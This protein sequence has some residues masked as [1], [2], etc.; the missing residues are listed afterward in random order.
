MVAKPGL[1]IYTFAPKDVSGDPESCQQAH[2][3]LKT[4]WRRCDVL[5]IKDSVSGL[6]TPTE[7]PTIFAVHDPVFRILAA[8]ANVEQADTGDYQAFLFEY[9]DVLGF[10]ANLEM[11]C[12]ATDIKKWRVLLDEWT[13][14]TAAEMPSAI[15]GEFYLFTALHEHDISLHDSKGARDYMTTVSNLTKQAS[16]AFSTNGGPPWRATSPYISDEGY[17]IWGGDELNKR[18]TVALLAPRDKEDQLFKWTVWPEPGFLAPFARYLM[19]TAKLHYAQQVFDAEIQGLRKISRELDQALGDIVSVYQ[20]SEDEGMWRQHEITE[21]HKGLVLE[22]RR[23]FDLM[24]G[25]SKLTELSFTT[26]IAARNMQELLPPPHP[27]MKLTDNTFFE[28]DRVRGAWLSEQIQMDLGYLTA[29]RERVS[30]GH[31]IASLLLERETQKTSRRLKNLV[32]IQGTLI[33]S[34]TIGLLMLPAFDVFDND[35][36]VSAVLVLLMSIVLVLPVLFERWHEAYTLLD[37]LAGGMLGATVLFFVVTF[38]PH[39]LPA[40]EVPVSAYVIYNIVTCF[41]GF[42]LGYFGVRQLE[43]FKT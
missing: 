42:V 11:N 19:H 15:M 20:K 43:K 40:K 26:R 33:G 10:I 31:K 18:R 2:E 3:Y 12:P 28:R 36:M 24:Y 37:R 35:L 6:N 23:N 41:G 32:L 14:N 16:R 9:Q 4:L 22:Q 39:V 1:I 21:A 17:C 7:F 25:I 34:L 27:K 13:S 38:W 30:E 5:G 29:L 8:K